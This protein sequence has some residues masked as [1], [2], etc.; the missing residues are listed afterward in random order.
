LKR[1][2]AAVRVRHFQGRQRRNPAAGLRRTRSEG[3]STRDDRS[4]FG[5]VAD[6]LNGLGDIL[7]V[8]LFIGNSNGGTLELCILD[9]V[10]E[11]FAAGVEEL[12]VA[13]RFKVLRR[14]LDT[15]RA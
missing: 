7:A 14:R 3:K 2:T 13:V 6:Q 8:L 1:C 5:V 11:I 9:A 10:G 4:W 15:G 12:G